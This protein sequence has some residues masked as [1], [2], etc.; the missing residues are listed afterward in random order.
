MENRILQLEKFEEILSYTFKQIEL[1]D[2]A[3]THRSF[4]NENQS[5]DL[6]DNERLEFLGDAVLDLCISDILMREFPDY[7]EGHLSKMRASIV[8]EQHLAEL[9]RQFGIGDFLLLGK[10][11]E[12]SGGRSKNS[13]LS[14]AFEA[15]IAAIYLDNGFETV[16][17]YIQNIF[18]PFLEKWIQHP[19]YRDY[20]TYL[21]EFCQNRFKVIPKYRM[22]QEFGPDHNKIFHI[23]LSIADILTTIG[24]GKN[25]KEAE[26]HAAKQALE[27]L[28]KMGLIQSGEDQLK[29]SHS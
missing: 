8:N 25:K 1:L 16:Y 24:I 15:V 2:R 27:E 3:L 21:Q 29:L 5:L 28:K 20:K 23:R 22:V 7:T 18:E 10:G 17:R 26:Q 19:V 6:Q 12:L 14:N 4:I 11:E 13:I 9:A